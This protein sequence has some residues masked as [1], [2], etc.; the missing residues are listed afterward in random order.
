MSAD[1]PYRTV[2]EIEALKKRSACTFNAAN[3][4]DFSSTDDTALAG[5]KGKRNEQS[6]DYSCVSWEHTRR[7]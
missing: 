4:F 5:E 6:S 7:I 1:V 2:V 3:D